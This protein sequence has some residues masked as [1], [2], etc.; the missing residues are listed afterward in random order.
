MVCQY[1]L[2]WPIVA[3]LRRA[4]SLGIFKAHGCFIFPVCPVPGLVVGRFVALVCTSL[5]E[6]PPFQELREKGVPFLQLGGREM[7][8][9]KGQGHLYHVVGLCSSL[10]NL[11][12]TTMY[13]QKQWK[14]RQTAQWCCC[15]AAGKQ[16]GRLPR[17]HQEISPRWPQLSY[18]SSVVAV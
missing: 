13:L 15:T 12:E 4:L 17:R 14:T 16:P 1:W 9:G 11:V 6:A 3:L 7:P 10:L 5:W 18:K 8:C 2:T